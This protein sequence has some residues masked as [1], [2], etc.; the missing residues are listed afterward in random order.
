MVCVVLEFLEEVDL[1]VGVVAGKE[2]RRESRPGSCR[3]TKVET[4]VEAASCVP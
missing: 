1:H 2:G 4:A 3:R